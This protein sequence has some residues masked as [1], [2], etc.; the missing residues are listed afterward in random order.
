MTV[1]RSDTADLQRLIET[2]QID[3]DLITVDV[4]DKTPK[5]EKSPTAKDVDKEK[6]PTAKDVDK[7][8]SSTDTES[9]TVEKSRVEQND[10][11]THDEDDKKAKE[12]V[13]KREDV[14]TSPSIAKKRKLDEDQES[15]TV[16]NKKP[17]N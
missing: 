2:L 6:S 4:V 3:P 9:K 5:V 12:N 11:S 15:E 8:K 10:S 13:D 7:E 16:D 17:K 14:E 1:D